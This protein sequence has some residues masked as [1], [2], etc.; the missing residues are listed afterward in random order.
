M[1]R[2]RLLNKETCKCKV[3]AIQMVSTDL[4]DTNLATMLA[5]VKLAANRGAELVVLPEYFSF[6]GQSEDEKVKWAEEDNNESSANT[7]KIQTVLS[8]AAKENSVWLIGGT[9]PIFA[10]SENKVC[11]AMFVF[12]Q[13]GN[14]RARYDKIHLFKYKNGVEIYDESTFCEAGNQPLMV[15]TPAGKTFLSVCY[16]LRFPEFYRRRIP[17]DVFPDVIIVSAAFTRTTGEAHWEVLLRA[18]AIE[19]QAYVIASAQGGAHN[20]GRETWGHSMII[21]PWGDIIAKC[22][23]G[24]HIVL[25]EVDMKKLQKIRRDLPALEHQEFNLRKRLSC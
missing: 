21:D 10:K 20:S 6:I 14:R 3:A 19:N 2:G 12:D 16:D 23:F 17:E 22:K 24:N 18:R 25:G 13:K 4:V 5:Q 7:Q 11:N 15:D 1:R 8:K 9:C